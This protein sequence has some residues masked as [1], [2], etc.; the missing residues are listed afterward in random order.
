MCGMMIVVIRSCCFGTRAA[1]TF[2]QIV[3]GA[4]FHDGTLMLF[5]R[6]CLDLFNVFLSVGFGFVAASYACQQSESL[7]CVSSSC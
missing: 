4:V 1:H 6:L 2:R 5:L 3:F 7:S